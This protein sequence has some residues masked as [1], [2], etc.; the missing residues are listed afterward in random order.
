MDMIPIET[1]EDTEKKGRVAWGLY[2]TR[3]NKILIN[4]VYGPPGHGDEE[5][6]NQFFENTKSTIIFFSNILLTTWK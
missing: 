3:D 5:A 1:G 6:N 4:G 2:D